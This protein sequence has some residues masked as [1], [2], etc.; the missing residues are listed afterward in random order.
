M[1]TSAAALAL[2][3][4]MVIMVPSRCRIDPLVSNAGFCL[5]AIH[6]RMRGQPNQ[7]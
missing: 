7:L 5:P 4:V 6:T 2:A 1:P 3:C